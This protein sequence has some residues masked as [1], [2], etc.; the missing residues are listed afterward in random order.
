MP[1]VMQDN[2]P[3]PTDPNDVLAIILIDLDV[4]ERFGLL[5]TADMD[6]A[7]LDAGW[8]AVGPDGAPEDVVAWFRPRAD[9]ALAA[10]VAAGAR[11]VR[12]RWDA[13]RAAVTVEPVDPSDI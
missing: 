1:L 10:A 8:A 3:Q 12:L 6:D 5:T 4:I 7:I 13:H 2:S 11:I 9:A